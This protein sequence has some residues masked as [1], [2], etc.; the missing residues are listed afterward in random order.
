LLTKKAKDIA[1]ITAIAGMSVLMI[2]QG[3]VLHYTP[4]AICGALSLTALGLIAVWIQPWTEWK[5]SD[6]D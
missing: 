5:E 2:V 3:C 1:C 6:A 4:R